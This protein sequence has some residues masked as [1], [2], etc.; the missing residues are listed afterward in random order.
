MAEEMNV[1]MNGYVHLIDW[2][3]SGRHGGGRGESVK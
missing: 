3:T 1:Q 2:A